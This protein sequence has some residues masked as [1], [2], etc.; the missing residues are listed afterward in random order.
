MRCGVAISDIAPITVGAVSKDQKVNTAP[1]VSNFGQ[2]RTDGA[3][4]HNLMQKFLHAFI[5]SVIYFI[6]LFI[7]YTDLTPTEG[8][9]MWDD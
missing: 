6:Y 9:P 8:R 4:M 2:H 7:S 1:S 5:T 3:P